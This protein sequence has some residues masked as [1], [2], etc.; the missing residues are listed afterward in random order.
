MLKFS[1]KIE[2][3][4][5]SIFFYPEFQVFKSFFTLLFNSLLKGQ[6]SQ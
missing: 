5:K 3:E 6:V 2:E 1:E 4:K